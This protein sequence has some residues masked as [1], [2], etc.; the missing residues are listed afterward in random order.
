MAD[1]K[2]STGLSGLDRVLRGLMPGDN[3]VWQVE[4]VA[5]FLPFAAPFAQTAVAQGDRLVYFRFAEHE[6]LAPKRCRPWSTGS[7][8]PT[9][10]SNSSPTSTRPLKRRDRGR[11]SSSI[12][13]R[14]W[15]KTGAATGCWA[16][17]SCSPVRS[18]SSSIRWP[19]SPSCA[20]AIRS[21]PRRPSPRPRRFCWTFIG[22]RGN[23][24]SIRR[25]SRVATRPPCTCCTAGT[26]TCSAR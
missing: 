8:R 11:F 3:L 15:P 17:S 13:S 6:P 1:H 25:R 10:S 19:I 20:T 14:P 5:D 18:S 23:S 22:T 2:L 24:T 9:A 21:T 12:A 16:I 4:S 7:A 26:A